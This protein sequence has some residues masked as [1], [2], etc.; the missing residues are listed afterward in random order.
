MANEAILPQRKWLHYKLQ[1]TGRMLMK[2]EWVDGFEIKAVAENGEIVISANREGL[3]SLAKQLTALADGVPGVHI[4]YDE[5]N[6][7]K[8]GSAELVIEKI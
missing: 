3:L 4:H 5:H 1:F 7:L 6:S 2:V 8:D